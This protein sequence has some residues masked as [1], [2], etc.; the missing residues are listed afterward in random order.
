MLGTL[1]EADFFLDYSES[2]TVLES[3]N[4]FKS[5]EH[6]RGVANGLI[7]PSCDGPYDV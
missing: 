7:L 4:W 2:K 1:S 3:Y 6:V 5:M